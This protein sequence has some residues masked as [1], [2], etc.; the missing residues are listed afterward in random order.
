MMEEEWEIFEEIMDDGAGALAEALME[1]WVLQ[2]PGAPNVELQM[3][4]VVFEDVLL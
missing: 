1:N 3:H 2:V 4:E